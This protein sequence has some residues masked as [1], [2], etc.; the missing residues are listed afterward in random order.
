MR[1][2]SSNGI[3]MASSSNS[4]SASGGNGN[5]PNMTN[6]Q[7]AQHDAITKGLKAFYDTVAAEPVPEE[8]T[9]LLKKLSEGG[10]DKN[11]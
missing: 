10:T 3:A 4:P 1:E 8:F 6:S 7:K 2:R 9:K 5:K 11:S